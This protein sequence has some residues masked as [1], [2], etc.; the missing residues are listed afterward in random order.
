MESLKLNALDEEDLAIISTQLQDAVLRVGDLLYQPTHH[1]FAMVL[2]RF[3][4]LHAEQKGENIRHR[5]MLRIE[6]VLAAHYKQINL[7][8]TDRVLE[9]L[10]IS[11]EPLSAP[12]GYLIFVFAD[13]PAIRLHVECIELQMR[14]LGASWQVDSK[15][16]HHLEDAG[17]VE[18]P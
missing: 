8:Q 14:D 2:N 9:L 12:E 3:D 4:W 5:C 1:S 7:K 15:P 18:G 13:G 6:R 16:E 10:A 11:F 17:E